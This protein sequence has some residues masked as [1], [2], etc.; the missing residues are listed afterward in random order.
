MRTSLHNLDS[1][2]P[3][4]AGQPIRAGVS[5]QHRIAASNK[6]IRPPLT[7]E[8]GSEIPP[9]SALIRIRWS[10]GSS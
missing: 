2:E 6:P 7:L 9:W 1:F 3:T 5:G 10:H 4:H 8:I